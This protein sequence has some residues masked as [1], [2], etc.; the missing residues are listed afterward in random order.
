ME[1][2][3]FLVLAGVGWR[4]GSFGEAKGALL[5]TFLLR[6]TSLKAPVCF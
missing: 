1:S 5:E 4:G 3:E 6:G 2:G